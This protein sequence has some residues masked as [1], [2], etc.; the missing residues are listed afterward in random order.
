MWPKKIYNFFPWTQI[1][2]FFRKRRNI[3]TE[4][5]LNICI[6]CILANFPTKNKHRRPCAR[7]AHS[8][9]SFSFMISCHIGGRFY[10]NSVTWWLCWPMPRYRPPA[11]PW[12]HKVLCP[13][14]R[15]HNIHGIRC[16]PMTSIVSLLF[17]KIKQLL[18]CDSNSNLKVGRGEGVRGFLSYRFH[19]LEPLEVMQKIKLTGQITSPLFQSFVLYPTIFEVV[20]RLHTTFNF[21]GSLKGVHFIH[22]VESL[23]HHNNDHTFD[24]I[25]W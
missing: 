13:A 20:N 12:V 19:T 25:G 14:L 24:S 8:I 17:Y 9:W 7:Q 5:S 21:Q 11:L 3:L 1:R 15:A 18:S 22:D 2:W 23:V 10:C 4:Y 6:L 16:M